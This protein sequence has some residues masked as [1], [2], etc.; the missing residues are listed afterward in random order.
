MTR[1]PPTSDSDRALL[2][3]V[4][5]A[6]PRA[7]V[8]VDPLDTTVEEFD[9]LT[10]P[11]QIVDDVIGRLL[12]RHDLTPADAA[13]ARTIVEVAVGRI[14]E[15]LAHAHEI[16]NNRLLQVAAGAPAGDRTLARLAALETW[17]DNDVNP[18]R[19]HLTGVD[20]RN[21]RIGRI[22]QTIKNLRCDLEA[23]DEALRA[24]IGSPEEAATV[25]QVAGAVKSIG[26]RTWV[27]ITAAVLAAGGGG[28]GVLTRDQARDAAVRADAR[29]EIRLEVFEQWLLRLGERLDN[30]ISRGRIRAAD[31]QPTRNP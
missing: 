4:R 7:G 30:F 19:L 9:A 28:Y 23:A 31:D 18:W 29:L 13:L 26:K 12:A 15:H 21:G 6:T 16:M 27:A 24:D 25:R 1:R 11:P 20:D 17:R 22:D 3:R 14:G 10:P 2:G 8:P 5:V